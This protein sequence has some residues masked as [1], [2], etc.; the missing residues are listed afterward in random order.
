MLVTLICRAAGRKAVLLSLLVGV[1]LL[2]AGPLPGVAQRRRPALPPP[3]PFKAPPFR[4]V[5]VVAP[6]GNGVV[7]SGHLDAVT[8]PTI[9][10]SYGPD[11][12]GRP[13]ETVTAKVSP[14]GDF[15]LALP[16]LA[17]P[18]EARLGYGSEFATLYLTPGDDL[19]LAFDPGRLDQ[20]IAFTGGG[21]NANNYL[22]Q[23]YRLASQ[24]DEARRT[25]DARVAPPMP[26]ASGGGRRWPLSRRRTHCRRLFCASSSR[27]STTSGPA[28]C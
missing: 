14:A 3:P 17:A 18:T 20:T 28:R 4:A 25:P 13:T 6:I 5:P 22:A 27:P 23:S 19:R 24:D 9:S 2:L 1:G 10:L 12:R 15:R 7:V 11:W 21:A 16:P 26:T 8:A